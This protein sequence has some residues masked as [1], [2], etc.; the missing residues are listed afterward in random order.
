MSLFHHHF[1]G[2]RPNE[3]IVLFLRRHWII[4]FAFVF[5]LFIMMLIPPI[6]AGVIYLI[7]PDI[8]IDQTSGLYIL[9][10]ELVSIYYLSTFLVYLHSFVDYHL[11]FWVVTNQRIISIEQNGL[12]NR[13]IA[14]LHVEKVQDVSSA[15]KGKIQTF[16]NYGHVYIQTAGAI[17]KFS[18]DEVPNPSHVAKVI[19]QV[20]DRM[21]QQGEFKQHQ[22]HTEHGHTA[23]PQR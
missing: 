7:N 19:L 3:T 2:Q 10:I 15:V 1:P 16:L 8:E 4:A 9:V 11:D 21:T 22:T 20:H 6:I 14:E 18:F 5:R 13:T 17:E 23:T 12:F